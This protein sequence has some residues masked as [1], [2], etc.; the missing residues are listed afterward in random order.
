MIGQLCR[1]VKAARFK[2]LQHNPLLGE[3]L[4]RSLCFSTRLCNSLHLLPPLWRQTSGPAFERSHSDT[5][6]YKYG[7]KNTN[8]AVIWLQWLVLI[9][10]D[11]F[12][13]MQ[14][15]YWF[16]LVALPDRCWGGEK[17]AQTSWHWLIQLCCDAELNQQLRSVT[18]MQISN[19][20]LQQQPGLRCTFKSIQIMGCVRLTTPHLSPGAC[21]PQSLISDISC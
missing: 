12:P 17:Q 6:V 16:S 7:Q 8:T 11:S 18:A 19:W 9:W 20:Q 5:F 14:P 10:L 13:Y 4:S 21:K 1:V 2:W 3:N 15:L